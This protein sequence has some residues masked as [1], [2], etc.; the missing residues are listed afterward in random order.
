M[1][2]P[3]NIYFSS[4]DIGHS[5]IL[6]LLSLPWNSFMNKIQDVLFAEHMHQYNNLFVNLQKK[7]EREVTGESVNPNQLAFSEAQIS[8]E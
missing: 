8:K 7:N 4:C 3:E 1:V 5:P 6:N 2:S